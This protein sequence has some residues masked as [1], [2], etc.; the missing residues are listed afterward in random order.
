MIDMWAYTLHMCV[1]V[2]VHENNNNVEEEEEKSSHKY[3]IFRAQDDA[4]IGTCTNCLMK[5]LG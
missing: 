4:Y 1:C 3:V 5:N 2:F